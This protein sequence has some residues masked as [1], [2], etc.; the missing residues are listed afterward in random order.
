MKGLSRYFI[1]SAALFAAVTVIVLARSIVIEEGII[2]PAT[3]HLPDYSLSG[4]YA[5]K[6]LAVYL[7]H[8]QDR[9]A[10]EDFLTLEEALE[11][12]KAVVHETGNVGQLEIE[13][14]ANDENIFI[15]A[16]DI[17]KGGKQDRVV[18]YD[19]VLPPGSRGTRLKTFCV[20]RGRWSRRG[21]ESTARFGSSGDR[22][23]TKGLKLAA[24]HY[25][26]QTRVWGQV[27]RAQNSLSGSLGAPVNSPSSAS[28][29]QLTLENRNVKEAVKEYTRNLS[30]VVAGKSDVIGY[31]FAINGDVN[32]IDVYASSALFKKLWPRLLK[33]SAV[34][35][36]AS[37]SGDSPSDP[38]SVRE[39]TEVIADA[40]RGRATEKRTA[41]NMRMETR[42]TGRSL[43][44]KSRVYSHR[45]MKQ[46]GEIHTNYVAK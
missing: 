16:G 8:G 34:E 44:F 27:N 4:P 7:V 6:N 30:L 32:S 39:V 13:N 26:S 45:S 10:G 21:T 33:A 20:E 12:R 37:R 41:P 23:A 46:L 5:H 43:V 19:L 28:S 25:G 29:L 11:Q 2:K 1:L 31:A 42:E 15:Q 24:K 18:A 17:L 22:V 35:A 3:V 38:P 36:V 9:V 14:L 40:E